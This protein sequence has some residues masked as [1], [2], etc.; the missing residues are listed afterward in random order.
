ML[1]SS[2]LES[3]QLFD[4]LGVVGQAVLAL[5]PPVGQWGI[6]RL[7]DGALYLSHRIVARIR[8]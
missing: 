8:V 7:E 6:G 3:F 4:V 5:D 2:V 1:H